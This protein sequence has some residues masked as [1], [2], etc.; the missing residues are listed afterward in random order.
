MSNRATQPAI[1]GWQSQPPAG[2]WP[3]TYIAE[4]GQKF[5]LKGFS[6][7]QVV[8]N[9]NALLKLNQWYI[10]DAHTWAIANGVWTSRDP[11]RALPNAV[12]VAQLPPREEFRP[13]R[14]SGHRP[15]W[16]TKPENYGRALWSYGHLFGCTFNKQAWSAWI[17]HVSL[18][19][20]P[21]RSPS[22]GCAKCHAE[23]QGILHDS[24]PDAVNNE[25]DAAAWTF[26]AHNRVN[27][28]IG[29]MPMTW[30]GAARMHSWKV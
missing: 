20:D 18:M 24:P 27:A 26:L 6:A 22:T 8:D 3:F 16:E 28:K 19:L 17:E 2:G 23:W 4:N 7:Q 10:S 12:T 1:R 30:R 11:E 13:A 25:Q 9:L 15:Y 5:P 29:K 21:R 14:E